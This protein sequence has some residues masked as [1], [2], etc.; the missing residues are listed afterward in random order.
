MVLRGGPR[1]RVGRRRTFFRQGLLR[2]GVALDACPG[3]I[4]PRRPRLARW[5]PSTDDEPGEPVSE[6][7]NRGDR[8]ERRPASS[9]RPPGG[10]GR[11][12]GSSGRPSGGGS[13]GRTGGGPGGRGRPAAGGSSSGRPDRGRK[14]DR[15]GS[16]RPV[17]PRRVEP[18]LPD[19][20]TGAEL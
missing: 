13:G 8:P 9:G 12:G 7:D 4:G 6:S 16:D 1:G 11:S 18:P 17:R 19:D 10:S 20:V 2:F 14:P 3:T 5:R 15:P